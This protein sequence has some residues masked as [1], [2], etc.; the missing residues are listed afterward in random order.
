MSTAPNARPDRIAERGQN[1]GQVRFDRRDAAPTIDVVG[2]DI[3]RDEIDELTVGVQ[4]GHRFRE[5]SP[6]RVT[7]LVDARITTRPADG[8]A[9][10]HAGSRLAAAAELLEP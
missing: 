9:L 8:G 3:D 6:V 7:A 2:T 1:Q 5:L 4:K 10:D